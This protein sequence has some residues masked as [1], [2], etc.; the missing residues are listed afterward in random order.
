MF[1]M[2]TVSQIMTPQ[3]DN[4][5][6]AIIT[7]V[8]TV[9]FVQLIRKFGNV[10]SGLVGPELNLLAYGFL[11]DTT[12]KALRGVEYWPRFEQFVW[13]FGNGT[14]LHVNKGTTLFIMSF[15]NLVVMGANLKLS[16]YAEESIK[17]KPKGW[18]TRLLKCSVTS[19]GTFSMFLFLFVQSIWEN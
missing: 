12:V 11:W 17:T 1:P 6:Y 10:P 19:L 9:F 15:L 2:L 16:N 5:F 8:I 14:A 18:R 13:S 4:L 7:V 3:P